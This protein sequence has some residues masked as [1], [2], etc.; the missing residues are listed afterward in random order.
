MCVLAL[1]GGAE[2]ISWLR[3]PQNQFE[4]S[5]STPIFHQNFINP[6]LVRV[7]ERKPDRPVCAAGEHI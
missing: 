5:A 6:F 2:A 4:S 1:A 7:Q 3:G